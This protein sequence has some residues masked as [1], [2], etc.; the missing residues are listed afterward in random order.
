VAHEPLL[1]FDLG[2]VA[3]AVDERKGLII[4]LV[5]QEYACIAR[6]PATPLLMIVSAVSRWST[7][8]L[9]HE[10]PRIGFAGAPL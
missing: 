2:S 1:E 5:D 3:V 10:R 6:V 8:S 7:G 4:E 9:C